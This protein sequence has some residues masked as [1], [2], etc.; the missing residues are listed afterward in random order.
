MWADDKTDPDVAARNAA[1]DAAIERAGGAP[2]VTLITIE[3][4]FE[5]KR[6]LFALRY[7]CRAKGKK[8]GHYR[9]TVGDIARAASRP[10][11]LVAQHLRDAWLICMTVDPG[12]PM[13]EWAVEED[14]D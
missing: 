1:I 9:T 6:V 14:G 10:A 3:Q 13:E 8:C 2:K 7:Q 11:P 12:A 5:H 4:Q